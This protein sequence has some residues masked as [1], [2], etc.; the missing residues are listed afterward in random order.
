MTGWPVGAGVAEG[1]PVAPTGQPVIVFAR[2]W[3]HE[4]GI[5]PSE[6]QRKVNALDPVNMVDGYVI[7]QPAQAEVS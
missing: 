4:N 1:V 2:T 7:L 3:A 6:F 5:T